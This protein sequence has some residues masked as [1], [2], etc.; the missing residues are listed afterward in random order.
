ML[1][2][3]LKTTGLS[4]A[5]A[6]FARFIYS[7]PL[8]AVL[9]TLYASASQQ[10]FPSMP[11][12]FW[13]FALTGGLTQILATMCVV[14][15]FSHRNFAVGI[16]FKKTEVVLTAIVGFVLLGEG[17]AWAGGLAIG[18]GLI[19]VLL[20]SDPPGGTGPFAQ[21]HPQPRRRARAAVGRVLCG[22]RRGL[23]R[24][25]AGAGRRRHGAAGGHHAGR[26]HR[27]PDA[28]DGGSGWPGAS[29]ARSPPSCA[30]GASRGWSGSPR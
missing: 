10:S 15:L 3:Q 11:G 22:L 9:I 2:K 7:A 26:G 12:R 23:S 19:G 24:R 5:G 16:T 18:I 4:T 25:V 20:L 14:A 1:Q 17:I 6:T 8:V 13:A 28:G 21:P 30:P 29:A 27:Q